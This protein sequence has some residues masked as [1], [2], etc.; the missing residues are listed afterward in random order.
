MRKFLIFP[1]HD[2][3]IGVKFDDRLNI[4]IEKASNFRQ[5][6]DFR[7]VL[8]IRRRRD[9]GVAKSQREKRFRYAR[10]G[11]NNANAARRSGFRRLAAVRPAV[12]RSVRPATARQ[13]RRYNRRNR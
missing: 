11:R 10:D 13:R 9:N 7:R 1:Q 6:G 12:S 4:N 2:D 8:A 5:V 3:E